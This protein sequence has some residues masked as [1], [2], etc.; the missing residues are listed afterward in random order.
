MTTAAL[1]EL[2]IIAQ[3]NT[4]SGYAAGQ[5]FGKIFMAVFAAAVLWKIFNRD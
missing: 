1:T 4:S 2:V 5:L 3:Q